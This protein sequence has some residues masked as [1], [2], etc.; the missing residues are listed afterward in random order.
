M[1]ERG[2]SAPAGNQNPGRSVRGFWMNE[3]SQLTLTMGKE[4]MVEH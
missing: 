3:L 1:L 2:E 4:R